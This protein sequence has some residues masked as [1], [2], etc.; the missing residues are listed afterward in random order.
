MHPVQNVEL[1]HVSIPL[2]TKVE[3][4]H[5]VPH[6]LPS[7]DGESAARSTI[8]CARRGSSCVR[9]HSISSS[10]CAST[11]RNIARKGQEGL[12]VVGVDAHALRRWQ[13]VDAPPTYLQQH[14][15]DEE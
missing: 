7:S 3:S 4:F 14:E 13:I 11:M 9:L 8:F 10:H 12:T 6:H 15:G 5:H 2:Q 1:T